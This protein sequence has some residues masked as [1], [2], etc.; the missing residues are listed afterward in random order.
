VKK[1]EIKKII[2]KYNNKYIDYN[3]KLAKWDK[4]II[5]N[6]IKVKKEEEAFDKKEK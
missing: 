4:E 5:T 3:N 1:E 2:E 6:P